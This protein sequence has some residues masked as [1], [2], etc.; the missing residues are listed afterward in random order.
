M[1][2]LILSFYYP[3]DLG[4]GSLRAKSLLDALLD[5]SKDPIHVDV[6]TTMPNRY[7]SFSSNT[8]ELEVYKSAFIHRFSLTAHHNNLIGQSKAFVLFA[9]RAIKFTKN[10]KYNLVLAT[11]GRLMTATLGALISKRCNAKLYLD[12]RDLFTDHIKNVLNFFLLKIFIPILTIIEKWTFCS[13]DKIN[14]VSGGFIEH[15]KRVAP[16]QSI[17]IYTNGVDQET[18]D[19]NFVN[20]KINSLPLILY[21]GTIGASQGLHYLFSSLDDSWKKKAQFLFVGDGSKRQKLQELINDKLWTNFEIINPEPRN[22]L[23][24]RYQQADVLFLHLNDYDSLHKVLPSK[25]FEYAASGKPILAGVEGYAAKFLKE[26]V[27]GVEI[28]KP[29]DV[30]AM[31]IGLQK[32]L[33]GPKIINRKNFN[34]RYLRKNI[35]QNMAKNILALAKNIK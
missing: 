35:T 18:I 10:K 33:K 25:I 17:S 29:G 32:L 31:K 5:Y 27:L 4:P 3:P 11:S 8:L 30:F 12:I 20:T 1:R 13:A 2:I 7:H 21:A 16:S 9:W 15:M 19:Y 26:E 28:F 14:V 6:V 23:Y 24:I 34:L 22:Q